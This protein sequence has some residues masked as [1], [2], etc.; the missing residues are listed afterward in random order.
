M[1]MNGITL[2]TILLIYVGFTVFLDGLC[3]AKSKSNR[4]WFAILPLGGIISLLIQ[5]WRSK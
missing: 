4:L 3:Y 1:E 5:N 2:Y